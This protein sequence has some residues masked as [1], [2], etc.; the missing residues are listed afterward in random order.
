MGKLK[1]VSTANWS[2]KTKK[3]VVPVRTVQDTHGSRKMRKARSLSLAVS[4]LMAIDNEAAA[5][6]K[7]LA[8][9]SENIKTAEEHLDEAI[10]TKSDV[11]RFIRPTLEKLQKQRTEITTKMAAVQ[12]MQHKAEMRFRSLLKAFSLTKVG[13]ALE[14]AP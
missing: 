6:E 10:E 2:P 3:I 13:L 7:E 14:E 4:D 11:V 12:V 5:L 8:Q 9:V 1:R